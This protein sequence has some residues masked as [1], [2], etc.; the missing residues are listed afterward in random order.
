[1]SANARSLNSQIPSKTTFL[2][3]RVRLPFG[4]LVF[5]DPLSNDRN[6]ISFLQLTRLLGASMLLWVAL[7]VGTSALLY[8]IGFAIG[9][10]NF[11]LPTLGV[12]GYLLL[13]L[14]SRRQ[15]ALAFII[16]GTLIATA[17]LIAGSLYDLSSDGQTYHQEAIILLK[18]GWNPYLGDPIRNWHEL[19]INHYAK[20]SEVFGAVLY[21]LTGSIEVGKCFNL[22][23][24]LASW[25]LAFAALRE[26]GLAW[27]ASLWLSSLLAFNPVSL[28]QVF[29][30]YVDGA[31]SS[32]LIIFMS[33]LFLAIKHPGRSD[34]LVLF[35]SLVL[36]CTLKFT[37]LVYAGLLMLG[38]IAFLILLGRQLLLIRLVPVAIAAMI[39]GVFVVGFNPY[40]TNVVRQGH[41]FHPLAGPNP[42][43]IMT[44]N[45]PANF[46]GETR[47]SKF[48]L[49]TFARSDSPLTPQI[50]HLK[51]PVSLSGSEIKIFKV[52]DPRVG[53]FGPFFAASLLLA[54]AIV[55]VACRV[56][57]P[58]MPAALVLVAML[59][60]ATLANPEGWWARYAPQFWLVPMVLGLWVLRHGKAQRLRRVNAVLLALISLN[61]ALVAAG[62]AYGQYSGNRDLR[63]QL[64]RLRQQPTPVHVNFHEYL[65]NRV[66][67]E[68]AGVS[69]VEVTGK[70]DPLA[71]R[72]VNSNTEILFDAAQE[73]IA[74]PSPR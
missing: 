35:T 71:E 61:S 21:W 19:W 42:I 25:A 13:V 18:D 4:P 16:L 32:L 9:G 47:L 49:A 37:G 7:I 54:F 2:F 57:V 3:E 33:A 44:S 27:A 22:L 63:A 53:A 45:M 40:V 26:F 34:Y 62:Y 46:A 12:I 29:S 43:D 66:R 64:E 24:I 72:L 67:L 6:D 41:P 11:Y 56:N 36:L 20:G 15:S 65:A 10:L 60:G 50:S 38:A 70:R 8:F 55:I 59:T 74:S 52:P 1:M 17:M 23:L 69:F 28:Y 30:Y 14:R 5:G 39:V 68:N 48:V 73:E 51:F 58:G 31:L